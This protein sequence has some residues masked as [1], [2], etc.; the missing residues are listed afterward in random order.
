MN[1]KKNE[2]NEEIDEKIALVMEIKVLISKLI[3]KLKALNIVSVCAI[4]CLLVI[5]S[6]IF[7]RQ[8]R[9]S[10]TAII[11]IVICFIIFAR[12]KRKANH[13]EELLKTIF[14]GAGEFKKLFLEQNKEID[15]ENPTYALDAML[16]SYPNE[17]LKSF[18]DIF[19]KYL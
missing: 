14:D 13:I 3:K 2:T 12:S 8:I 16:L 10:T 7:V 1:R 4:I 11:V 9:V 15:P 19:D 17:K 18:R 6:L 5:G